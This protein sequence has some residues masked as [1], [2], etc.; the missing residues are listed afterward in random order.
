MVAE[1]FDK[2]S[3][4]TDDDD[5]ATLT[6]RGDHPCEWI[7]QVCMQTAF[8]FVQH[9]KFRRTRGVERCRQGNVTQGAVRQF[10]CVEGAVKTILT[11]RKTK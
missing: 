9:H 1:R 5:L 4:V 10:R 8:R 11:D 3:G 7:Q 6:R 2:R